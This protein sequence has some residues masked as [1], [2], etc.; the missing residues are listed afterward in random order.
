[1]SY[2]RRYK[3]NYRRRAPAPQS[4]GSKVWQGIKK[5]GG[6]AIKALSMLNSEEKNITFTKSSTISTATSDIT[7]INGLQQGTTDSTRVGDDVRFKSLFIRMAILQNSL[8]GTS[9]PIRIIVLRD[10]Q[11][12]GA[13]P[14]GTNILTNANDYL[15]PLN[16]DYSRRFKILKDKMI[17]VHQNG[18]AMQL[19]KWYF[20]LDKQQTHTGGKGST[21]HRTD[22]GL[23]NAGTVADISTGAYYIVFLSNSADGPIVEYT[24]RMRYVD[25]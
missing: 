1:M 18:S 12:N 14:S 6:M 20:D 21:Q 9:Q 23:G 25:N 7:L 15:S 2:R 16:L 13:A 4:G 10:N 3:R 19:L 24:S 11:S 8:G 22:Y 5:V 17:S